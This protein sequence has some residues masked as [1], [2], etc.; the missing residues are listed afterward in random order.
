MIQK[1]RL[2]ILFSTTRQWN[3]GD[4]FILMGCINLLSEFLN[5]NPVI[6]NRNPQI[7]YVIGWKKRM[8]NNIF[9]AIFGRYF[10][11]PFVDN[12][13]KPSS[14]GEWIDLVVFAGSPAWYGAPS[15]DLYQFILKNKLPVVFLGIGIG[16]PL[17]KDHLKPY[18]KEVITRAKLIT[19]RDIK[20]KT[21]LEE[22]GAMQLPCPALLSSTQQKT[23]SKVD[24][25]GL[26]FASHHGTS[27]NRI[28]EDSSNFLLKF[29][30]EIIRQFPE[31]EMDIICHY[32][33]E[34]DVVNEAFPDQQVYYSYDSKDYL[35]I[36]NKYDLVIGSRVHGIGICASMGIPG[37]MISHDIRSDTVRGFN[38]TLINTDT[39]LVDAIELVRKEINNADQKSK[40][41]A[42]HKEETKKAYLKLLKS[43]IE[44]IDDGS[45]NQ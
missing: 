17:K 25:I 41:L 7:R 23:I 8:I 9:K 35:S 32:I 14:K 15:E 3:P 44:K 24:R 37:I 12:S 27:D 43:S 28:D 10:F 6:Y 1:S 20:A 34:M 11:G 21:L 38:A 39:E 31:I 5:F 36:Y 19:T 26:I 33:D 18:E 30:H 22:Y 16:E 42:A 29:F 13:I 40:L 4:E 45:L 2:N